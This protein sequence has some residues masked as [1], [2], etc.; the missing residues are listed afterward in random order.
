MS[1]SINTAVW[2]VYKHTHT[3]THT[4]AH[5]TI[6][7]TH[8]HIYIYIYIYIYISQIIRRQSNISL[9][10][11]STHT[12]SKFLSQ[13]HIAITNTYHNNHNTHTHTHTHN[14]THTN[15]LTHT[16]SNPISN[17]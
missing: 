17:T 14:L 7:N 10:T 15:N 9:T 13:S 6:S 8:T 16:Q 4:H 5:T 12:F 2:T 3:H 11:L 1:V